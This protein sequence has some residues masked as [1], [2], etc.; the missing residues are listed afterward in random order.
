MESPQETHL[1]PEENFTLRGF[2]CFRKDVQPD[3]RARG[4]VA[5]FVKDS[6]PAEKIELNT[7]LQTVAI[8]IKAPIELTICNIY[9]PNPQWTVHGIQNILN[10]LPEPS[11]IVGDW[12]AHSQLWGTQLRNTCGIDTPPQELNL[13]ERWLTNKANWDAFSNYVSIPDPNDF[14]NIEEAVDC[15]TEAILLAATESIPKSSTRKTSKEVPWWNEN[16][17]E[18]VSARKRH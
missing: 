2:Q 15:I 11:I 5:T 4:G 3:L 1:K 6:I 14:N 13:R 17:R 18:A 8:R 12:N 7:N 10:Q 9:L 16:V